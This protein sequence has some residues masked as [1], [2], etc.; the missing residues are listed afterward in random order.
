MSTEIFQQGTSSEGWIVSK[1][2]SETAIFDYY[3]KNSNTAA[4]MSATDTHLYIHMRCDIAPFIDY[5]YFRLSSTSAGTTDYEQW[6]IVDN[7][8]SI[9]WYGEWKT[10]IIDVNA[11]PNSSNGTLTLSDVRSIGIVVDNSNSGNIRSIENTYIDVIR[12]G[13]GITCYESTSTAFDFADIE[14]IANNTTNK[15][16]IIEKIGGI[17]FV[18][19]RITIGDSS[20]TNYGNFAS[21]DETVVFLDASVSGEVITSTLYQLNFVGNSTNTTN[22][23]I[24]VGVGS[25]SGRTGRNGSTIMGETSSVTVDVS[26]TA[27]VNLLDLFGSTFRQLAGDINFE[28]ATSSDEIAGCSFDGCDQVNTGSAAV[29]NC[30]FLNTV[31]VATSGALL[32]DEAEIDAQYCLF[33][34]NPVGIEVPTL[35]A[36][37]TL[38]GMSFSGNTYDVRY[39]GASDYDCNYDADTPSI[40]NAGAGTLTAVS[41]PITVTITVKDINTQNA[42]EDARVLLVAADATGDLPFEESVTSINRSGSTATVNHTAHGMATGDIALIAGAN[43]N[44]YNGAFPITVTTANTYT[45]TVPGTPTSPATGTIESTG[46]YFNDLTNASGVVSDTRSISKD[47]PMTGRV[48]YST[49]ANRYKTSPLSF[50]VDSAD[51]YSV[52]VFMIPDD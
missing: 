22:I 18:R 8:S 24:G 1:N 47:Q 34:N 32:W 9:E 20:G 45:Y 46:G 48:R 23:Q 21:Q 42:L 26:S 6:R 16:G 3:T 14:A 36:N 43:Q 31:A 13:T 2:A 52:I 38:T 29:R 50:T 5:L 35:T 37:M 25:G 27:D 40:Q 10:F 33:V 39:E 4:D 17:F 19:G 7:T 51:G 15:Y 28:T 30:N 12:F 49:G 41:D 44:E 11:T